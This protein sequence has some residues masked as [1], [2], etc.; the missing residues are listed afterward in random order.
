[1]LHL[2]TGSTRPAA[3]SDPFRITEA[4]RA[5]RHTLDTDGMLETNTSTLALRGLTAEEVIQHLATVPFL[6]AARLVVV[7]GLLVSLGTA[8]GVLER[9]QPLLDFLPDAP[10]TN[11]LVLL[12]PAPQRDHRTTLSRSPLYRALRDLADADVQ[13][14]PELRLYGRESGNEVARWAR[15]R[16]TDRGIELEAAAAE[17]LSEL[18]GPDL[19][20]LASEV[21]KLG[22]HAHGRP[23]TAEDVRLL[24]AQARA[25]DIFGIVDAVVEGRAAEA[26]R[27]VHRMVD[28]GT[29]SPPRIQAMIARQLRNLV[30]AGELQEQGAPPSAV[31][32]ATGVRHPFAQ[33]KLLRQVART[34]RATAE[35]GLRAIE[36]SDHAVKTGRI[37]ETLA[38]E[39]LVYRLAG[40]ADRAAPAGR[41]R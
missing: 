7:E 26:L 41:R 24:T 17:L 9:W 37:E 27:A 16:A 40:L 18:L 21:E 34:P 20:A 38:L 3:G 25:E 33:Q 29:E 2:Y 31:G 12:E 5:L 19:W 22:A 11:H 8:R 13:E 28:A 35:A 4:Y 36:S 1:M 30:R 39:L 6:A 10:P 32:E 14:F 23:V 15:E